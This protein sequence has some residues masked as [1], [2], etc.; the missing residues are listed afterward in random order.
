MYTFIGDTIMI[1][2]DLFKGLTED[3]FEKIE[4]CFN[5]KRIAFKKDQT[6][7]SNAKNCKKAPVGTTLHRIFYICNL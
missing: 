6:I 3:E 5:M 4:K 1:S 7:L 2:C